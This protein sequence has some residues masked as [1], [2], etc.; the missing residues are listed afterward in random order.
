MSAEILCASERPTGESL[1]AAAAVGEPSV[2]QAP[3]SAA[4]IPAD[5]GER[6]SAL[7]GLNIL[8]TAPTPAFDSVT[9]LAASTLG[10]PVVLVSLV[11]EKRQWFKSRVGVEATQTG[12]DESFCA[13]AVFDRRPLIVRD[14]ALDPRFAGNPLVVGP[15]HFRAYMGVPLFTRNGQA[16]GALCAIDVE[17]RDFADA[18]LVTLRG[19]AVIVEEFLARDYLQE[20]VALQTRRLQS[21]NL[22]LQKEVKKSIE[23]ER[24]LCKAEHRFRAIANNV[25]AVIGYWNDALCCESANEAYRDVYGFAPEAIVGMS[26]QALMGEGLFKLI[27]PHVRL[28]LDG[29]AQRFDRSVLKADGTRAHFDT[30][31]VPDTDETGYT[32]GLFMIETD[33]T[34]LRRAEL[35]MR[36]AG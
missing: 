5:E 8:D 32:R 13:H 17:P 6:L 36:A 15:L 14:A 33:V 19:F 25:P 23:A 7:R 20:Q 29:T 12:R 16:I 10:V 18:D 9:R 22:A 21:I 1:H 31:Y 2:R 26:L 3:W 35:A 4:A 28:A 24:A 34:A 27:E 11:D 30:Q